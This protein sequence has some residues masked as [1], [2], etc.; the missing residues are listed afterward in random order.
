MMLLHA[1]Y[2]SSAS[3]RV[4]LALAYKGLPYE[5]HPVSLLDGENRSEA[6]LA[7]NPIGQVPVLEVDHGGE[8]VLLAQSLAILEYLEET[9][10]EPALLPKDAVARARVREL[11]ELVN[12]GIQPL[13]NLP[14]LAR[15]DRELGGDSK[16]WACHFITQG[17]SALEQRARHTAKSYLVG[18]AFSFADICLL[19]QLYNARRFHVPLEAMPTLLRVEQA[20]HA[21]PALRA[22]AP[23]A[24]P[25]APKTT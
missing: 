22:A 5:V 17:L 12:A 9:H 20:C 19:P 24:Q 6:H 4:R 1:Y 3:Y 11:A 23:D 25:D 18:D 2:R 14:V 13:Q 10:P 7:R 8:R 21:L 16:A 15:V